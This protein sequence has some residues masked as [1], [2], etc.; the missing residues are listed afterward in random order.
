M[1]KVLIFTASTGGGH[2]QAA[3]S[4]EEEFIIQGFNVTKVDALK[5]TS[6]ILDLLIA[7]GYKV[8]AK[9]LPKLYGGLYKISD[10]KRINDKVTNILTKLVRKSLYEKIKKND[11]DLIIATHPFIV[12][13]VGSLKEKNKIHIPFISIVTDYHIHQTYVNRNVDAY[14]AGSNHTKECIIER[15]IP[16]D[17]IYSYGIPI[18][19]DFLKPKLVHKNDDAFTILLMGGSMGVRS[20]KKV[21]KNLVNNKNK[22]RVIVVCGNNRLL[23]KRLKRRFKN[24]YKNK[25]IIIYGFTKKIPILMD[26]S[27]IVITKPGGLTTSE[28]I[29]KKVPMLIP[30]MIPGQEEENA[31]YLVK[32][33]MAIRVTEINNINDIIYKITS[34][35]E[36]LNIMRDN[37]K[38]VA[39]NHSMGNIIELSNKL[40]K[41]YDT[42]WR[43]LYGE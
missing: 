37:M 13:V 28:A 16:K 31:D 24:V 41:D 33:N 36:I 42:A 18:R 4:L 29:A 8:L 9:N 27:D 21:L 7:D 14:I 2:N 10:K 22:L 3:T 40:I 15:G 5:E 43:V 19:K 12:N 17:R 20:I 39:S 32:S 38:K 30:Y 34:N 1:K 35:K 26:K 11:P 25:E 23:Q 6:K